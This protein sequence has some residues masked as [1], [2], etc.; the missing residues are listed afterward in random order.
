[1]MQ[2]E[3]RLPSSTA[4]MLRPAGFLDPVAGSATAAANSSGGA[5][6]ARRGRHG[7]ADAWRRYCG[8]YPP[9]REATTMD[10]GRRRAE[11]SQE[12]VLKMLTTKN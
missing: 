8:Q 5:D 2:V 7:M 3:R 12:V 1:M 10:A 9:G 4:G 6:R 11:V